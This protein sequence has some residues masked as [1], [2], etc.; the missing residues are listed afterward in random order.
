MNE[1]ENLELKIGF[2]TIF[3]KI[4]VILSPQLTELSP[5]S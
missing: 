4:N 3:F 1:N 2:G 5:K